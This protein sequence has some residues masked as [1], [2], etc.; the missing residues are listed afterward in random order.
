[1]GTCLLGFLLSVLATLIPSLIVIALLWWLDR[2]EKEPLWLL[3]IVFFWG[4]VPTIVLSLLAQIILDVPLAKVL[5]HTILYPLT[6]ISIVAPLTEETFK[7]L[8]ILALFVFYRREFDGVVDGI[9]YGDLVGF[10]FSVVED[11]FYFM[12]SLLGGEG[13]A[14]WGTTVALRVGLYNLNHALFAACTGVGFGLARN[15]RQLWKKLL[16]ILGGWLVA[17]TLHGIHNGGTVLAEATS[18]LSCLLLTAV[19]W[20]G[21]LGMMVLIL[22]GVRRESR[23]FEELEPEV[24]SGAI[25]S[26]EYQVASVYKTRVVR[27]WQVLTRHGVGTWLRWNRHVQLIVDLAYKKHQKKAA[28][29]GEKTD[30]IIAELRQRIAQGRVRLPRLEESR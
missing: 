21:A 11:V 16:F 28:G 4:A 6:S 30:A 9:L 20:M 22:V 18:G 25:T 17:M 2:Y 10:G 1:M 29:E 26:T 23:W 7:A 19:D 15:S 13:W 27:G 12:G 14:G 5:G 24:Q 8:I 3:S